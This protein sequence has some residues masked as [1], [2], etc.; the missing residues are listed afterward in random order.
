[1]PTAI[2]RCGAP[3]HWLPFACAGSGAY[4][5]LGGGTNPTLATTAPLVVA[6]SEY[7]TKVSVG[8]SFVCGTQASGPGQ[9][10][11]RGEA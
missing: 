4:G 9:P 7:W 1:M 2:P 6:G 11:G 3:T 5:S 8:D 10:S